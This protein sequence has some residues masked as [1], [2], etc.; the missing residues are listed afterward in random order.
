VVTW[1]GWYRKRGGTMT[2]AV[3][4]RMNGDPV[5]LCARLDRVMEP[6]V[7]PLKPLVARWNDSGRAVPGPIRIPADGQET[8]AFTSSTT[9]FS[10]RA[11]HFCSAYDTGHRF[12]SSRL[13]ASWKPRVEYRYLNLPESWKKTTTLPSAFA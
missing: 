9:F 4:L 11:L 10:T 1:S 8:A 13:A 2:V 3:R 5:F 6:H 12:P 7:R